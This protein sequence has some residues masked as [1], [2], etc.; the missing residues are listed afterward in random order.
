MNCNFKLDMQFKTHQDRV[1]HFIGSKPD[2][3][4]FMLRK[5]FFLPEINQS[6]VTI[7]WLD[8]CFRGEIYLPRQQEVHPVQLAS[9]PS[10]DDA[11][12]IL[13]SILEQVNPAQTNYVKLLH[14]IRDKE[15]DI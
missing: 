11:K 1:S 3:Y 12:K 5:K 10:K 13:I 2:F 8:R 4:R 14:H 6:V 7:D 9:P 15:M